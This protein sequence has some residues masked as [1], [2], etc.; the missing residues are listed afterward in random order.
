MSATTKIGKRYTVV[1][2]K[3]VREKV[4]LEEGQ[5]VRVKAEGNQIV[6]EPLPKEPLKVFAKLIPDTYSEEKYE[7]KAEE[8]LTKNARARH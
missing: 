4:N 7:K 5:N 6:I 2:P 3:S 8:A 1:V